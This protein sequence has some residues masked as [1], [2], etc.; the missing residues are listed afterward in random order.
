MDPKELGLF[1]SEGSQESEYFQSLMEED[2]NE[3]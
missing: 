2:K 1:I 3:D